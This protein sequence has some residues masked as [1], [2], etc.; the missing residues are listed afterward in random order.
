M[1]Q[2]RRGGDELVEHRVG[3][4]ESVELVLRVVMDGDVRAEG[5][6]APLEG[7]HAGEDLEQRGLARAVLAHEGD[8]LA[9]LHR[10]LHPG[11]DDVVAVGLVH[12][13]QRRHAPAR[14]RRLGELEVD[15]A[16]GAGQLDALDLGQHLH[17]ALHLPGLGRLVAEALDEPLDLLDAPGLVARLRLQQ[18]VAR[19]ALD[20]VVVIVARVDREAGRR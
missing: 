13:R 2:V 12:A 5:A 4:R 15:P 16:R 9:A 10:E 7:Q 6:L 11:I 19:L 1:R 17:A 20:E 3:R 18:R 8:A 14:A